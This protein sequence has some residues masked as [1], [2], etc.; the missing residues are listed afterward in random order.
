[1]FLIIDCVK[2]TYDI[3][4][5]KFGINSSAIT[6]TSYSI[7]HWH[8]SIG[9]SLNMIVSNMS[10]IVG[11][12][13]LMKLTEISSFVF[14]SCLK[15]IWKLNRHCIL[16]LCLSFTSIE[17]LKRSFILARETPKSKRKCKQML[18]DP[19]YRIFQ[20][21]FHL[22][23]KLKFSWFLKEGQFLLLRSS[24]FWETQGKLKQEARD[25]PKL[26]WF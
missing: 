3:Y 4:P 16:H 9:G 8:T 23:V 1:M 7:F 14:K 10:S 13:D 26:W 22:L 5:D 20:T 21:A 2:L 15:L 6:S 17:N 11:T 25:S 18:E 24:S 12:L 19:R